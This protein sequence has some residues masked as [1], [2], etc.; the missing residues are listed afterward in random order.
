[1]PTHATGPSNLRRVVAA[2]GTATADANA[3]QAMASTPR[4]GPVWRAA[5]LSALAAAAALALVAVA[6]VVLQVRTDV[7]GAGER[8]ARLAVIAGPVA[9]ADPERGAV[10]AAG[11]VDGA[12]RVVGPRGGVLAQAGP[13]RLWR[14][15]GPEWPGRLAT[16]GVSHWRMVDGAIEADRDLAGGRALVVRSPLPRGAGTVGGLELAVLLGVVAVGAVLAGALAALLARRRARRAGALAG[17]LDAL[18]TGRSS[19]AALPPARG[20]WGRLVTAARAADA[21]MAALQGAAELGFDGV[22]AVL[23]PLA[24]PVAARTPAGARVRNPALERLLSGLPV[25]DARTLETAVREGLDATGLVARRVALADGRTLEVEAWPASAGRL[26]A[27]ADRTERERL[28]G[29]RRRLAGAAAR[30]LQGPVAEI[31]ALGSALFRQ[32]PAE[33]AARVRRLLRAADRLERLVGRLLRG[34]ADEPGAAPVR[35]RPVAV[36]GFLWGLAHDWDRELRSRAL[37]VEVDVDPEVP[38]VETDPDLAREVLTELV[39]NAAK[40][41]QRGGTVRLAARPLPRGGVAFEV[42][43]NGPGLDRR[44]LPHVRERFYRGAAAETIP[45]AGLGL[46]VAAALAERLGG[47]LTLDPGPGGRA[48]LE[49]PAARPPTGRPISAAATAVPVGAAS[50]PEAAGA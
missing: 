50:G 41:T 7:S 39:D 2:E 18:G 13:R 23:A 46:G 45:G 34:T 3:I 33:S 43:D 37:R 15:G 31:Q 24:C 30:D 25:D 16:I 17:T 12:A 26:V 4:P 10:L 9:A 29:L 44:E 6:A 32:V 11:R 27:V 48:T 19:G 21:R 47:T 5:C 36:A 22:T 14:R 42:E 40:F 20:E 28:E 35:R 1:L 49:L 8:A 38:A